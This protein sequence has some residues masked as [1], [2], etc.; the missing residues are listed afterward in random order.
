MKITPIQKSAIMWLAP[1]VLGGLIAAGI[2]IHQA[3][4]MQSLLDDVRASGVVSEADLAPH[5]FGAW[6]ALYGGPLLFAVVM[7][8]FPFVFIRAWHGRKNGPGCGHFDS[9]IAH[10]KND[11]LKSIRGNKDQKEAEE[12][13]KSLQARTVEAKG[14][15]RLTRRL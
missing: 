3:L 5:Q 14:E 2:C 13:A 7:F 15:D 6:V 12:Q 1:C 8:L 10:A 11:L 9:T 4:Y